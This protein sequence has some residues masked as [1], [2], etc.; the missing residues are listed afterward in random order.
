M[1][2]TA[3]QIGTILLKADRTMYKI[4]QIAYENMFAEDNEALDYERDIIFIYKKAV[5]FADDFFVGT[6]KLDKVVE[7]LAVKISAYDYGELN[8]IYADANTV[9]IPSVVAGAALNDLTDVTITNLLDNQLLR[10]NAATG[11]WINVGPGSAVRS[12]QAFIATAGQTVF[13]TSAPFDAGLFDLY[14]NGVKLNSLS[15]TTMGE[16]QI[17]LNDPC[18]AGDIIDVVIYDSYTGINPSIGSLNDLTDV[19]IGALAN[20]QALYYNSSTGLWQNGLVFVPYTGATAAV[21]LGE[22]EIRAG[23]FTLDTSPTGT[24]TVGTTRWNDTIGSSETTLKGGNVILKNGVD[25]VARVVNKVFPNATL[26][27]AQYQAVRV[28]G[29]Q[30]QRLAVAYA[31]ANNDAN[32]ADTIGLVTE[33]IATNQEGFI[34]TVGSLEGINTTG[35]LQGETWADGDVLYLSPTTP[36]AIT[37]IKPTGAT[38]H[39][40]VIGYVEYA[41]ANNG[42]IYVKTMNGWELDE[43]HNVSINTATLAN[44]DVLKYNSTTQLWENGVDAGGITG[45]GMA[46]QVPYFTG[47][48]AV[49]GSNNLFWDNT[50]GRLGIGTNA[51]SSVLHISG[52]NAIIRISRTGTVNDESAIILNNT[53]NTA[54]GQ[55]RALMGSGGMRFMN[56]N[57]VTEYARFTSADNFHIGTYT[58]DNGQRLQ[59]M[60][61]TL[62]RGSGNTSATTALTVQNSSSTNLLT[63]RNDGLSTFGGNMALTLNGNSITSFT[64]S[65]TTVGT[66]AQSRIV[67]TAGT[68]GSGIIGKVT[69]SYIAYKINNINDYYMYNFTSGDISI[70]NDVGTGTIKMAAGASSTSQFTIKANGTIN[71]SSLPTS[72]TGLVAGDLWNNGGVINIV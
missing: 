19:S 53:A 71:M 52:A 66:T 42:K 14:V 54:G 4:G 9:N 55:I 15:Y 41:H 62:L 57:A 27:K 61:D 26:T 37:N 67:L 5:E 12:S 43:L 25:L 49:S 38:G 70:L 28:S 11:Q 3:P 44:N 40:V 59:V 39:I 13:T 63:V 60:G 35:S 7:R 64:I 36:G 17:T 29:A 51:P 56:F 30:G 24:A 21:N 22:F 10:Y 48:S 31:Q 20:N 46:G 23:Q 72:A 69:S 1:A 50:N 34:M 33:T 65:N 58:S 8:P 32:S 6:D 16:Y 47:A 18:I 45:T 68:S 2:Y